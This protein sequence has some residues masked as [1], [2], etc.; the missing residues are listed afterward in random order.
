MQWKSNLVMAHLHRMQLSAAG[1]RVAPTGPTPL[2]PHMHVVAT[3]LPTGKSQP[4]QQAGQLV[5]TQPPL[6]LPTLK[7]SLLS[8]VS[9]KRWM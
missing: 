7:S 8:G 3:E 6:L 9:L 5:S 1:K 2:S 4:C